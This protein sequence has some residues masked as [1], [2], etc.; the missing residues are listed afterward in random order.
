MKEEKPGFIV[1]FF[2]K[3]Y[4]TKNIMELVKAPVSAISGVS[5]SDAENL[6]QAFGIETVEDLAKNRY[7]KLAQGISFFSTCSGE[8]LDKEF[9]S[10][11]YENLAKKPVSAISGVS[12][13]DALLLKKAFRIE[14][15]QDLAENKYVN[16]AQT[17]T[18]L[19]SLV[20]VLKLAGVL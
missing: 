16:I 3:A 5:G 1:K 8:I 13:K 7:V 17:A 2:D 9:E 15:I 11:E 6:K 19:A 4:E 12:E 10:K 18:S 14:T 20:Q